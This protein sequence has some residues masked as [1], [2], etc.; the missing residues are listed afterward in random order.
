MKCGSQTATGSVEGKMPVVCL[1]AKYIAE[2]D[3]TAPTA[4]GPAPP[5][6]D[7]PPWGESRF[8]K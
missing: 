3:T 2:I 6:E 1:E 4:E 8:V 5:D 7:A